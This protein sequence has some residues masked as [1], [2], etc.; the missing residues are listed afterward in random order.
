MRI[1]CIFTTLVLV[2]LLMFLPTSLQVRQEFPRSQMSTNLHCPNL[3][4]WANSAHFRKYPMMPYIVLF[5]RLLSSFA[6]LRIAFF[7]Q[8]PKDLSPLIWALSESKHSF[9]EDYINLQYFSFPI[10][11]IQVISIAFFPSSQPTL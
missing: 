6:T 9:S 1:S 11:F 5:M 8:K 3:P 7:G 4:S 2:I 10:N